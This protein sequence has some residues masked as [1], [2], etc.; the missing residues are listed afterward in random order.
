MGYKV[1][2]SERLCDLEKEVAKHI[3]EGWS[4]SGSMLTV[5]TADVNKPITLRCG[6]PKLFYL[7]PILLKL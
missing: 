4:V 7:Q 3:G 1:I 6:N 5:T 2:S